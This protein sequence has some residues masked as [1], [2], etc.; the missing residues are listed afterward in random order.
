MMKYKIFIIC[1]LLFTV[2]RLQAQKMI[3]WDDLAEVTFSQKYFEE[4]GDY[5]LTPNFKESVKLL[6]GK[7]VSLTGYFLNISPEES[8]YILSKTPMSA[9]FFCGVGGPET[10]VELQFLAKPFFKTDEIVTVTGVLKL[11]A[12]DVEHFNYIL[13]S[14]VARF[15]IKKTK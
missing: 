1:L 15:A 5:F 14:C 9:C 2:T 7:R 11:N 12:N 6:E 8:I 10:A 13:T 4:Y 3:T